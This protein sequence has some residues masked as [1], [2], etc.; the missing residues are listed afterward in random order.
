[1][2]FRYILNIGILSLLLVVSV[3]ATYAQGATNFRFNEVLIHNSSNYTDEFG[4]R[5][6]WIEIVNSSYSNVN[7]GGCYL[8]DDKNNLTKY[9][10]PT[11]SPS[12]MTEPREFVVFFG[13]DKTSRSIYHLN[14]TLDE[15]K[16]IYLVDANGSDIIDQIKIPTN[17]ENDI[18]YIRSNIDSDK[19]IISSHPTP[20]SNNNHD[21]KRSSGELFVEHDPSGGGMVIIA[22]TVVFSVLAILTIFYLLIGQIFTKKVTVNTT[23]KV[24]DKPKTKVLSGE[25][26]VAIAMAIYQYQNEIHDYENT[27]LTVKKVTKTYSP[28]NSK[29]Q[30]VGRLPS[31]K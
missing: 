21:R 24:E 22:M 18:T 26:N 23:S 11:D 2:R 3:R 9:W 1:M 25:I 20:R 19:W 7:I 4:E 15:G 13:S 5:N 6:S 16:T 8:S 17:I 14:F 31:R 10:I 12:T 27:V 30:L 29:L 28:W